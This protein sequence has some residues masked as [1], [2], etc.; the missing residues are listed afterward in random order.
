[1]LVLFNNPLL[2]YIWCWFIRTP[3]N[4]LHLLDFV[5]KMRCVTHMYV[6]IHAD[7]YIYKNHTK[8]ADCKRKRSHTHKSNLIAILSIEKP[9]FLSEFPLGIHKIKWHAANV[10]FLNQMS[11]FLPSHRIFVALF[12]QYLNKHVCLIGQ[13]YWE[14]FPCKCEYS[15]CTKVLITLE[16]HH[17]HQLKELKTKTNHKW[18]SGLYSIA[19]IQFSWLF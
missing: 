12:L 6:Y 18:M 16:S 4:C 7:T 5:T 11:S 15:Q 8:G 14:I 9:S 19:L 17:H 10:C 3:F 1:M 13:A 2:L